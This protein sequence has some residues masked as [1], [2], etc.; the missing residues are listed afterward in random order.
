MQIHTIGSCL[1]EPFT[2]TYAVMSDGIKDSDKRR[3]ISFLVAGFFCFFFCTLIGVGGISW[4]TPV[5]FMSSTGMGNQ[6]IPFDGATSGYCHVVTRSNLMTT[7]SSECAPKWH[8]PVNAAAGVATSLPSS[9]T[10]P[11]SQ[12]P[13]KPTWTEHGSSMN[14][15][16]SAQM[17]VFPD[18]LTC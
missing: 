9:R 4:L 15:S 3:R 16:I 11:T 6:C 7:V 2:P 17:W 14:F 8:W 12:W 10:W 18:L 5:H 1:C 13:E